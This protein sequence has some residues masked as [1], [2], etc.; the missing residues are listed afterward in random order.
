MSNTNHVSG[1]LID[2]A[3]LSTT[4][5]LQIGVGRGLE[6]LRHLVADGV[7]TVTVIDHDVVEN[8]NVL[9]SAYEDQDVGKPK[10]VA[11]GRILRATRPTLVY[12]GLQARCDDVADLAARMRQATLVKI[13]VDD[14]KAMFGLADMARDLGRDAIVAGTEGD[15]RQRYIA[16][17]F[18]EGPDLRAL[19]PGPWAGVQ[20]GQAKP[21]AFAST[22]MNAALLAAEVAR[23]V[24]GV[25]HARAGSDLAIA[26]EGRAFIRQPLLI[27][28]NGLHASSGQFLPMQ[29][30]APVVTVPSAA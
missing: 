8:R 22:R 4:A 14:A 6:H 1:G 18:A 28:L 15:N 24:A 10:V 26:A 27:G 13:C 16:G 23:V 5:I 21:R 7:P 11:A 9:T 12:E 20:N 2:R 3:L 19:L 29:L 30:A 17:V 25:L